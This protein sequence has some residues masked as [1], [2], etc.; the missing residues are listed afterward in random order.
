M[1]LLSI[2]V[3]GGKSPRHMWSISST[4]DVPVHPPGA[5]LLPSGSCRSILGLGVRTGDGREDDCSR[6]L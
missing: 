2:L 1:P 4:A 5:P 3:G 6:D